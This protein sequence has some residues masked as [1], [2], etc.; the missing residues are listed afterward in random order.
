M[1]RFNAPDLSA[2]GDPEALVPLDIENSIR[3][4]LTYLHQV[5]RKHGFDWN[6]GALET[7]PM[8]I[9]QQTN[10]Y[11]DTIVQ[12]RINDGIKSVLLAQASGNMLDHIAATYYGISRLFEEKDDDFRLRIALA[13]E[14][15]STAGPSGAY[16]FHTLE[17]NPDV[18]DAGVYSEE[19]GAVYADGTAVLAPEILVV[20][21]VHSGN[22][23][24]A[25]R[26]LDD[27]RAGL[28]A[29]DVRPLGDK[30]TV[31]PANILEYEIE[32][33][34]RIA[35]G[36]DSELLRGEAEQRVRDYVDRRRY[37]S[38]VHQR[39]GI[40]AALKVTG[41]EEVV[42][43][44]PATDIDPGSKGAGFCTKITITTETASESW[45]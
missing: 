25:V 36:A 12:G 45:R 41:A 3:Q 16:L 33:V 8:A 18:R 6:L 29:K 20:V 2:L 38:K 1:S 14:A 40:G 32:A 28:S 31:E 5:A 30:V 13:P 15:F 39:L 43:T 4:R 27:V 19:D 34:L 7:D 10:A 24:P 35:Q 26:T 22:G 9:G 37:V 17:A 42:L 23:I 11:F 21:L 44:H